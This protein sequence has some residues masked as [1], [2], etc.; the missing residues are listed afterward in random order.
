MKYSNKMVGS[1]MLASGILF[2]AG[3]SSALA[4]IK[5]LHGA[6]VKTDQGAALST[7]GGEY[8]ILG[9]NLSGMVGKT[10]LAKG[11]V[12]SGVL[13]N[14]IRIKSDKVVS[15]RDLI[16]PSTGKPTARNS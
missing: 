10:I 4:S 11:K 6:V 13:S 12:E 1:I 7:D 8:L 2:A 15:R 14:T 5:D 9:K 3:A 16:D